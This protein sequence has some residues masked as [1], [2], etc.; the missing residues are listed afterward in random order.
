MADQLASIHD[1]AQRAKAE[2][3]GVSENALRVW[4]ADG[5]L[6]FV[7]MGKKR[8]IYWPTLMQ[9]LMQGQK[10]DKTPRPMYG[11]GSRGGGRR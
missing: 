8:M 4:V 1:T 7:P 5:T 10:V 2:G 6:A 9:F 3:L 11:R